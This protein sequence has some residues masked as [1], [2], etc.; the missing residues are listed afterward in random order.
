MAVTSFA[1]LEQRETVSPRDLLDT[2]QDYA[3]TG[4]AILGQVVANIVWRTELSVDELSEISSLA[5]IGEAKHRA[6]EKPAEMKEAYQFQIL[7]ESVARRI[8]KLTK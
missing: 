3:E 1:D 2:L 5:T 7:V 6:N 4:A 8:A